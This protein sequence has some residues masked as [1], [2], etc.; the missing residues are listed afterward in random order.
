MA[1]TTPI[2]WRST[3]LRSVGEPVGMTSP[4][5]RTASAA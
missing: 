4:Y 5:T 1:A 3:R 2:G